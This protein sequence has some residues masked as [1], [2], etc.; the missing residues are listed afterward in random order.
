MFADT[1]V[2]T[3]MK[4]VHNDRKNL[5]RSFWGPIRLIGFFNNLLGIPAFSQSD[6]RRLCKGQFQI[7]FFPLHPPEQKIM[8]TNLEDTLIEDPFEKIASQV[9]SIPVDKIEDYKSSEYNHFDQLYKE[10]N[11]LLDNEGSSRKLRVDG[12]RRKCRYKVV[13]NFSEIEQVIRLNHN[14]E[15]QHTIA[16]VLAMEGLHSLGRGHAWHKNKENPFDVD[17]A[18][19]MSRI[20]S[21]K[22]LDSSSGP[23]WGQSPLVVNVTHAFDN[24]MFGH[25]QALSGT[26]SKIFDYSEPH[27]E[28]PNPGF[29]VGL[30]Q[31]MSAFGKEVIK[32]LLNLDDVSKNREKPGKRILPDIKHMST[33]TRK[34]YYEI[35]HAHNKVNPHDHIPIIISHSAVNGKPTL[36]ENEFNPQDNEEDYKSSTGFNPWSI[37]LYDDEIIGIHETEGLIGIIF[38]ERLLAGKEKLKKLRHRK[39]P[40]DKYSRQMRWLLLVVDQIEHIVKTIQKSNTTTDKKLVWERICIGSDF[41][42]QVNPINGYKKATD[43]PTFKRDLARMLSADRYIELRM[44]W[45][46][47]EVV[48]KICF[49]NVHGF[50]ERNFR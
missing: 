10:L 27:N 22:G 28:K 42:G 15:R 7:I 48:E 13:K 44:G 41:D 45:R 1:H 31:P 46:V 30:N 20:D 19:F 2:H 5:W 32:R 6:L 43:F 25:A 23:G 34:E 50:L 33:K 36:S 47:H 29:S 12:K 4:Y 8:Y 26:F 11:L 37:N 9:I 3:L 38:D 39:K 24:G 18:T 21:I 16:I 49:Q 14:D 17:D 40:F 35:I